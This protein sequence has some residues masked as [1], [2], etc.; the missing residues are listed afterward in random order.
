[1]SYLGIKSW[2]QTRLSNLQLKLGWA[3]WG[4]CAIYRDLIYGNYE[5]GAM[6][7]LSDDI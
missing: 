1:M 4:F 6:K 3:F 5:L 7:I 2:M